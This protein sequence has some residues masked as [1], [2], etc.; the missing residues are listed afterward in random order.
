[1]VYK[2]FLNWEKKILSF[3]KAGGG[4]DEAQRSVRKLLQ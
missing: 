1:M 4:M 3:M 2:L